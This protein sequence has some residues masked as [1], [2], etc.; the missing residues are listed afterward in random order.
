M[1]GLLAEAKTAFGAN[2]LYELFGVAP[3]CSEA[4]LKKAY[5]KAARKYH[6]DKEQE[7]KAGAT[8]RFQ[9][10]SKAHAVLSSP[11]ARQVLL[12]GGKDA[13][14]GLEGQSST[15]EMGK[16]KGLV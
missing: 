4:E 3:R 5:L 8:L 16:H 15:R 7:D 11:D 14:D 9:I 1:G 12:G 2:G 6:P 13:R 10:L